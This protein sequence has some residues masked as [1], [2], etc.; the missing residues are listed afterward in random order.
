MTWART[1]FRLWSVIGIA[2]V[3][4]S[5]AYSQPFALGLKAKG[6]KR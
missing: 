5:I 3:I 4:P 2:L 1:F 6:G